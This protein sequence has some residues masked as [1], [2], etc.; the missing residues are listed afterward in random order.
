MFFVYI[1]KSLKDE[2]FY[3]GQTDDIE[4]RIEQHNQGLSKYTSK[5]MPWE[6]VYKEEYTS[7]E[8]AMKREYFLKKQ[9]NRSF[10]NRLAEEFKI[11]TGSSAG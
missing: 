10:Y 9:R 11:R 2:S 4:K 7:R 3:I 1:I 8:D 6:L 5:K